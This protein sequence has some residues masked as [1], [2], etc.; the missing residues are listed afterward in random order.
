MDEPG[1]IIKL[2]LVQH[3]RDF[4]INSRHLTDIL[5]GL[6][7]GKLI[8]KQQQKKYKSPDGVQIK[9]MFFGKF[10]RKNN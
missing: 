8:V 2:S 1:Q 7:K 9:F 3:G 4:T 6:G 10:L 5:P